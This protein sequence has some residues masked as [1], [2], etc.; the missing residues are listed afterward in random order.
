M[1]LKFRMWDFRPVNFVLKNPSKCRL[2]EYNPQK[3]EQVYIKRYES[4]NILQ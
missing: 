1:E 3:N 2:R 4:S